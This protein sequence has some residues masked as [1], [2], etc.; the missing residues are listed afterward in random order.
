MVSVVVARSTTELG[1]DGTSLQQCQLTLQTIDE[2]HNLLA[3]A[4]RTGRLSMRLGQHGHILP[5][6]SIGT[7]LPDEF[8]Y[9][10][11]I[12]LLQG[13][14]DAERYTGI[15]DILRRKS[16]MDE[17]LVGIQ[18]AD[19]IKLLLDEILH[20]LD[21]MVR[22]CLDVLDTLCILYREITVDVAERFIQSGRE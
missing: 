12:H 20:S 7:Q 22:H 14:L 5:L 16:E 21:V 11:V 6:L 9:L 8:L 4:R 15:I 18:T 2:H 3:Q 10:G 13:I 1:R 19:G 17:L